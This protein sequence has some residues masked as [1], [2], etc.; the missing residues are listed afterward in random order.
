MKG[1]GWSCC[2]KTA[3]CNTDDEKDPQRRSRLIE[4]ARRTQEGTPVS[5]DSPAA[6]LD[7]LFDHPGNKAKRP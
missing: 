3:T 2:A 7:G 1:V 6:S 4:I 5:F